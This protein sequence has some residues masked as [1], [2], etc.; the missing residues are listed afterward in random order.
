LGRRRAQTTRESPGLASQLHFPRPGEA[1]GIGWLWQVSWPPH[2]QLLVF[3]LAV[4]PPPPRVSGYA[5]LTN[6]GRAKLWPTFS[7]YT[8]LVTDGSRIYYVESPFVA[9]AL[10]QVSAVGGETSAIVAPFPVNRDCR[11]ISDRSALLLPAFVAQENEAPLWVLPLP[12]GKL[13]TFGAACLATM[14]LVSGWAP[15]ALC[16]WPC[17]YVSS[18]MERIHQAS[19]R[20]QL[21]LVAALVTRRLAH[22]LFGIRPDTGSDSLWEMQADGTNPHPLLPGWNGPP[23]ECCGNW[24][25]DG[26]YSF[27]SPLAMARRTFGPCGQIMVWSAKLACRWG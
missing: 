22:S 25:P 21:C 19:L 5:Q 10:K 23:Q 8:A 11:H 6:D 7:V 4:P 18:P 3:R 26:K 12:T 16:Q 24:T 9:P 20:S 2:L 14:D 15:G 13:P 17:L 1:W 27:F